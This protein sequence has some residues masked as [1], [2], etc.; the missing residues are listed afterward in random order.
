MLRRPDR[1]LL[2]ETKVQTCDVV[3]SIEIKERMKNI[4]KLLKK[5]VVIEEEE[6][7]IFDKL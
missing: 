2:E 5:E 7:S 4:G 3:I 6:K 1:T